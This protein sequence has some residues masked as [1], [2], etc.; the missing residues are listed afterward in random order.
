M[1][2]TKKL[3]SML[4]VLCMVLAMLP[5]VALNASAADTMELSFDL[6]TN[7]GDWP[8]ENS[9]TL[10]EYAYSLGGVDYTFALMNV[11]CNSSG[12]LML[13]KVAV[14][15]L[16]A[17]SGYKLTKVVAYN[18]GGCSTSVKVGVSSS[19]TAASYITGGEA[20]TW[21]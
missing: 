15:G 5:T 21:S 17:I 10:T 12:Y 7:P 16:P 3:V 14:L 18:S 19:A 6:K 13:T 1:K 8:E 9:T 20:I 2:L 11:K 4:L